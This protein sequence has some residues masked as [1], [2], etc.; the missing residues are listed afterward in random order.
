MFYISVDFDYK[1]V[2]ARSDSN[3]AILARVVNHLKVCTESTVVFKKDDTVK[4][5]VYFSN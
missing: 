5:L 1:T 4:L 3:F 2:S